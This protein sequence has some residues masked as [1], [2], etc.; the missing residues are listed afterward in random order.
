MGYKEDLEKLKKGKQP[1][2]LIK[3]H[4]CIGLIKKMI[5]YRFVQFEQM[6]LHKNEK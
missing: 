6:T 3:V 5:V 1:C 2:H 4:F